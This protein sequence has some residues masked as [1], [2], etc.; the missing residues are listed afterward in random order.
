MSDNTPKKG[1]EEW[2]Y[3]DR[4]EAPPGGRD[5]RVPAFR[6]TCNKHP[7]RTALRQLQHLQLMFHR[8]SFPLTSVCHPNVSQWKG[9]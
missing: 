4:F 7:V 3:H 8:R 5:Q 9:R 2:C 6:D 1:I